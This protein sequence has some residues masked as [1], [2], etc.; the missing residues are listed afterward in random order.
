MGE[1][2]R[3]AALR[4]APFA[5]AALTFAVVLLLVNQPWSHSS[6]VAT[7]RTGPRAT[8]STSDDP[9][10][11][12]STTSTPD[13][14]GVA[15]GPTTVATAPRPGAA[16]TST[17]ART[18]TTISPWAGCVPAGTQAPQPRDRCW[19]TFNG[20]QGNDTG[21]NPSARG[22][23]V[24]NTGTYSASH[25]DL[26][27]TYD[28]TAAGGYV[29]DGPFNMIRIVRDGRTITIDG[30]AAPQCGTNVIQPGDAVYVDGRNSFDSN[31]YP[32][33]PSGAT[34]TTKVGDNFKCPDTAPQ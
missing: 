11:G 4:A 28:A 20:P 3:R 24:H 14:T 30:T 1:R 19:Q 32:T 12:S 23:V 31:G 29:S 6:H 17:P 2:T 21:G 13:A 34:T 33:S 16:T 26:H 15:P 10:A 8:T 25:D 22:C 18:T 5:G 9:A 27:C 7:K